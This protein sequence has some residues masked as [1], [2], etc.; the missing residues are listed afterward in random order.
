MHRRTLSFEFRNMF[1][2]AY[3]QAVA[4]AGSLH[5]IRSPV[6]GQIDNEIAHPI[7]RTIQ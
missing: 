1:R 6:F 7:A 4:T 3:M 2:N 5:L